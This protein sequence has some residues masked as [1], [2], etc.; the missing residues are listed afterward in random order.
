VSVFNLERWLRDNSWLRHAACGSAPDPDIF[1]PQHGNTINASD[2]LRAKE[3]CS[4]CPVQSQCLDEAQ[5]HGIW[6]G[7]TAVERGRQYLKAI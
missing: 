1:F 6:G 2:A 7:K 3:Y 5:P 4:V